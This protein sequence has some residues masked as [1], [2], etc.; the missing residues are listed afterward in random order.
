LYHLHPVFG[1]YRRQY[2]WRCGSLRKRFLQVFV[3][4]GSHPT[5]VVGSRLT[6]GA[7]V[8]EPEFSAGILCQCFPQQLRM[9]KGDHGISRGMD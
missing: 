6:V 5:L 9:G 7:A 2:E 3:E 4:K 8:I 1:R